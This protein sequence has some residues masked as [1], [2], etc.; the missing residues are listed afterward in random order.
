VPFLL[1]KISISTYLV[2]ND[3]PID[4]LVPDVMDDIGQCPSQPEMNG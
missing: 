3:I 2:G 4:P 1:L